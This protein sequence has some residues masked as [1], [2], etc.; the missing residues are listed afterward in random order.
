[1]HEHFMES[2]SA[3][4]AHALSVGDARFRLLAGYVE[5]VRTLRFGR[6]PRPRFAAHPATRSALSGRGVR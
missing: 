3:I 5:R 2:D 4:S 6:L 1:M